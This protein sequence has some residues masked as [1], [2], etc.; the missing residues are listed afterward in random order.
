MGKKASPD[1]C[2]DL[3]HPKFNAFVVLFRSRQETADPTGTCTPRFGRVADC[4][5]EDKAGEGTTLGN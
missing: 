1:F 2:N 5:T 3:L 4:S